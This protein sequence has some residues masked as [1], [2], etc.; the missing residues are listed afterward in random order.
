MITPMCVYK[1]VSG[2]TTHQTIENQ[3]NTTIDHQ[4]IIESQIINNTYTVM[5][6]QESGARYKYLSRLISPNVVGLFDGDSTASF[7]T[8][9][10]QAIKRDANLI[11]QITSF[12]MNRSEY[13][14][15]LLK[16]RDTQNKYKRPFDLV[17]E[18]SSNGLNLQPGCPSANTMCRPKYWL[19]YAWL[20]HDLDD[21][22]IKMISDEC[23]GESFADQNQKA[24][25]TYINRKITDSII[26]TYINMNARD[27]MCLY[28][29]PQHSQNGIYYKSDN[30]KQKNT[31][32]QNLTKEVI[33]DLIDNIDD[34]IDIL[35][36]KLPQLMISDIK[37]NLSISDLRM[38]ISNAI[39]L[40][41]Q[42][43]ST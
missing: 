23:N 30:A 10:Y 19:L 21:D 43:Q 6:N 13:D 11:D 17:K 15:L 1:N 20:N 2:N 12:D 16:D 3:T 7:N 38:T 25:D 42:S 35:F 39:Q 32:L 31:C 37:L 40:A 4:T 28:S 24:F 41:I 14:L 22:Q 34:I 5:L 8:H 26:N 9:L 27:R 33:N 36:S 29:P 18:L